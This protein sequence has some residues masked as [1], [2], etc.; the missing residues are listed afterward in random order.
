MLQSIDSVL[1]TIWRSTRH[2]WPKYRRKRV[3]FDDDQD[4]L[5]MISAQLVMAR[6][7]L[8]SEVLPSI[9]ER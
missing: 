4:K 1:G 3:G 6:A 9:S 7:L 2:E 8:M 5:Q